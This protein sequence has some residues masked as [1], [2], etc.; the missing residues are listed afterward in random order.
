M[1]CYLCILGVE[2][3]V[4]LCTEIRDVY[5]FLFPLWAKPEFNEI[6]DVHKSS[7]PVGAAQESGSPPHGKGD[8]QD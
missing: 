4:V 1:K 8:Q 3:E 6:T 5:F 2:S 7:A